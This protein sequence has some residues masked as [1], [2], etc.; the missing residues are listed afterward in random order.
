VEHSNLKILNSV[1]NIL[2]QTQVAS[3]GSMGKLMGDKA[4]LVMIKMTNG[5]LSK[6]NNPGFDLIGPSFIPEFDLGEN[7][8]YE[9]KLRR[10]SVTACNFEKSKIGK[11]DIG[12]V[13]WYDAENLQPYQAFALSHDVVEKLCHSARA[14][15]TPKVCREQGYEFTE[16]LKSFW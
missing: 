12:I 13:I 1:I 2:H 5:V 6:D 14:H 8:R 3:K 10:K 11:F 16:E 7:C 4:E 9:V 15:I